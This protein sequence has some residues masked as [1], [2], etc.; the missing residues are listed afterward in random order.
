MQ[1]HSLS[2]Q[3]FL[4]VGT[5]TGVA[6]TLNACGTSQTPEAPQTNDREQLQPLAEVMTT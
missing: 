5:V 4:K 3:G 1:R 6:F 2:R